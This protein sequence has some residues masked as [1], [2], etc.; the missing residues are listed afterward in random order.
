MRA[1][2]D[3]PGRAEHAGLHHQ[4]Q[5][6]AAGD[7]PH[8]G[9]SGSSSAI[10]SAS[11][12]GSASSNGVIAPPPALRPGVERRLQPR[13]E[14]L[15]HLLRLRAQHRLADAAELAGQRR[16]DRV[17]RSW[18]RRRLFV[19]AVSERRGQPPDDAERRAFDLGLDL[20]RRLDARQLDRHLELEF[21]VGDLGLEHR[22]VVVG[23]D[24]VK[25]VHAVDAGGEEARIAQGG[26][27]RLARRLDD[28]VTGK[29]HRARKV[30]RGGG[31]EVG[32]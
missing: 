6:G 29:F 28:D 30:G 11:E 10:A 12:R 2:A 22:R 1:Q 32:S 17:V 15:L 14:L 21:H 25:I 18:S 16:L 27:H 23:S 24:L 3:E 7:R 5:R 31:R 20:A 4:H 13:G 19:S 9:S 8:A 26:K